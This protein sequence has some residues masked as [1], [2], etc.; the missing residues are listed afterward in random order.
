MSADLSCPACGSEFDA[1]VVFAH[2]ANQQAFSRLAEVSIPLGDRVMLYVT[3]FTPPKTRLTSAKKLKLLLQ[4]LPDLE[5]RAITHKGREWSVPLEV[6]AQA[7]DQMLL[8]RNQGKLE[9]PMKGHG[10]LYSVLSGMVDKREGQAE[11][12]READR[13]TPVRQD[14]VT[15][16]GQTL[17]IGEALQVAYAGK[18]P[19]LAAI[20]ANAG[21][22]GNVPA[23]SR[24]QLA[25]LRGAK[26]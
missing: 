26:P 14:T 18:D 19:A 4:L 22:G 8:A 2:E 5:R 10:Y 7:F 12:Q 16:R 13:R 15:V 17:P 3:L 9:L 1:G 20:D 21:P 6:W 11:Q 24:E 25:R 23:S